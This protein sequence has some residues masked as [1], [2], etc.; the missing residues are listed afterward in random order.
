MKGVQAGDNESWYAR[1]KVMAEYVEEGGRR[2]LSEGHTVTAWKNLFRASNYY[3][4]AQAVLEFTDSRK[5]PTYLKTVECFKQ[6]C[7]YHSPSIE[8]V[9]IPY[10]ST[11]MNGYVFQ[12][13]GDS[14]AK[15]PGLVWFGG[16]D[17]PAEELYF[18]GASE[19]IRRG[20]TV[21][22]V[23]GPGQGLSLYARGLAGRADYEKPF[24]AAIDFFQK[25]SGIDPDRIA[26]MG[27]SL[28]GYYV[29]RAAAFE[30]RAK[31]CVAYD[32]AY[33]VT[34]DLYDFFKPIQ[35]TLQ[36]IVG[37]KD[38]REA[39]E[40]LKQYTL[41][42]ICSKVTCPVL[43]VHGEQDYIM[44]PGA[45]SRVQNELSSSASVGVKMYAGGHSVREYHKELLSYVFDWVVDALR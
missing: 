31:A 26:I 19:A 45:V 34:E 32:V 8:P 2:A 11:E 36:W 23:N 41:K 4:Q 30:K 9:E 38:D 40:K 29:L 13:Y 10:Q 16:A 43:L 21:L 20:L 18:Q 42:G 27:N 33:D 37:A 15:G 5:V 6:A 22:A 35:P 3:R 25:R 28:G 12:R 44:R 39:R 24:S 14:D 1:W 17:S 7:R